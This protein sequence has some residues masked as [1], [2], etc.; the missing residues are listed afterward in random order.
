MTYSDLK[1]SVNEAWN[2]FYKVLQAEGIDTYQLDTNLDRK[3]VFNSVMDC[4]I[5]LAPLEEE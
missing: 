5:G 1:V 2:A 4:V 3:D